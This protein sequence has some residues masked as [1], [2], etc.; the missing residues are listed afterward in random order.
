MSEQPILCLMG[1][2]LKENCDAANQLI[3]KGYVPFSPITHSHPIE[4]NR[5]LYN[6]RIKTCRDCGRWL[7][8]GKCKCGQEYKILDEIPEPDYVALDL[9]ILGAMCPYDDD[10][11]CGKC[12]Q[13]RCNHE[14]DER[15]EILQYQERVVGV[16]LPSALTCGAEGSCDIGSRGSSRSCW[17]EQCCWIRWNSNGAKAEYEFCK[18]HHILVISLETALTKPFNEWAMEGL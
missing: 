15:G 3:A 14:F 6:Y 1:G 2:S 7:D 12:W 18:Q 10:R 13:R 8:S 11:V 17:Q 5:S 4:E 16:V 9:A